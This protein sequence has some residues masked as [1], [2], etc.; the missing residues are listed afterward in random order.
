MKRNNKFVVGITGGSGCGKSHLA[1]LLKERG[2]GVVDA[3]EVAKT[4]MQKGEECLGETVR[5]FGEGILE[6]D[7][8]LNRKKLAK[9]VFSDKEKLLKLNEISHKYILKGIED[10]IDASGS[11]VV[12]V[13]GA[14]LIESGFSCDVMIGVLAGYDCRMMRIMRRDRL[15]EAE[16]KTRLDAQQKDEFY[17]K[18]CDFVVYNDEDGFDIEEILKRIK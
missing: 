13:D 17:H 12:F 11:D 8:Q 7:G 5:E 2:Y 9:I 1:S 18:N 3:D 10:R 16:A 15:S 6:E 14:V 4:V